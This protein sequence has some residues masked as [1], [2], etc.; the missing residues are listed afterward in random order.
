MN[1]E[2]LDE[3]CYHY[4][5]EKY[6]GSKHYWKKG[7]LGGAY[8][9]FIVAYDVIEESEIHDDEKKIEHDK[10]LEPRKIALEDSYT[11]FPP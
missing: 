11:Y 8:H 2:Q 5:D 10:L 4:E 7:W 3:N 1:I 6:V 9:S